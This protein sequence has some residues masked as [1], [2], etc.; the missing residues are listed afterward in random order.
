M[1]L[2]FEKR[3]LTHEQMITFHSSGA[4]VQPLIFEYV[5]SLYNEVPED[6][7]AMVELLLTMIDF[8]NLSAFVERQVLDD[9][10]SDMVDLVTHALQIDALL[11]KWEKSIENKPMWHI[12]VGETSELPAEACYKG[13]FYRYRNIQYA[14]I[15]SYYRWARILVDSM[16]LNFAQQCPHSTTVALAQAKAGSEDTVTSGGDSLEGFRLRM[17]RVIRKCAEDIFI[18]TPTHWRH[19]GI[20]MSEYA[21]IAT[22]MPPS[23]ARGGAGAVGLIPALFLLQTAACA[24]GVPQE[25]WHWAVG[26]INTVWAFLG[27]H[28]ARV[29]G[30]TMRSHRDSLQREK[31]SSGVL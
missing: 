9:G 21:K 8:I 1:K 20:P 14:R 19:P 18:S 7:Q 22:P 31:S 10:R 4:T 27:V 13:R 30:D 28:Q 11:M 16:L 26:V 12:E 2:P 24:P 29:L 3:R 15:W 6:D 23:I 17:L 5:S 25:D